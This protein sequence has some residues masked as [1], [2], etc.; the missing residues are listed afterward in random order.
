MAGNLERG[1]GMDTDQKGL[2]IRL[3]LIT[4]VFIACPFSMMAIMRYGNS[5][6][7]WLNAIVLV[8]S[9]PLFPLSLV[10]L[11]WTAWRGVTIHGMAKMEAWWWIS[12][13]FSVAY[14]LSLL[15][16]RTEAFGHVLAPFAL[17]WMVAVVSS[18]IWALASVYRLVVAR[19]TKFSTEQ[20]AMLAMVVLVAVL[21]IALRAT[22]TR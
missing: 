17:V 10:V 15:V 16:F 3:L 14:P 9:L 6:P 12:V 19:T 8:A 5:F 1:V 2:L 13:P 22:A 21:L 11:S 4:G 20:A 7:W 18:G